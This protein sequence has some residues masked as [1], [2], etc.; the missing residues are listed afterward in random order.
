MWSGVVG[1]GHPGS[2]DVRLTSQPRWLSS[3]VTLVVSPASIASQI[4]RLTAA[5]ALLSAMVRGVEELPPPDAISFNP[6]LDVLCAAGEAELTQVSASRVQ[7]PAPKRAPGK[8]RSAK[9]PPPFT[10]SVAASIQIVS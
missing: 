5:I 1:H 4:F 10:L 9:P 8:K 3:L 2:F 7:P 6:V